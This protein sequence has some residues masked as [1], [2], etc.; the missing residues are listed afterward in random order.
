VGLLVF[1][2][3]CS[4]LDQTFWLGHVGERNASLTSAE[5]QKNTFG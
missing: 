5:E 1:L 2:L 4:D 3:D